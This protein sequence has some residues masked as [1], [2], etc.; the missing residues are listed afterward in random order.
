[1]NLWLVINLKCTYW[2]DSF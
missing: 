2:Y 1:M